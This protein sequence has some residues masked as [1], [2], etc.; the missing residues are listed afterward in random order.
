M[1]PRLH[2][3]SPRYDVGA[4][5][6]SSPPRAACVLFVLAQL[7]VGAA[8]DPVRFMLVSSP[9]DS[10]V[11]VAPLP[12]AEQFAEGL[13]L[14][15]AEVLID[16]VASKC[17]SNCDAES[18]LGLQSPE[19]LAVRHGPHNATLYVADY[20]AANI[21]SYKVEKR[22]AVLSI[23]TRDALKVGPQQ[24]VV[25]GVQGVRGL[26]VD[27]FGTLYFSTDTGT[28]GMVD[29]AAP[30]NGTG[31]YTPKILYQAPSQPTVSTPASVAASS[32]FVYWAN[33]AAGQSSGSV[34]KAS[35]HSSQDIAYSGNNATNMSNLVPAALATNSDK[36]YGVCLTS[37]SI[38]YTAEAQSVYG[39][40][41][42]GGGGAEVTA[43][44]QQPRGCV[45]DGEGFLYVADLQDQAV[46]AMSVGPTAVRPVDQLHRV[47]D[48]P[49][50]SQV[51][52]F[53]SCLRYVEGQEDNGFL[54]LGW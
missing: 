17:S 54:G 22:D 42:S 21:Y 4:A 14:K 11:Y 34:V 23:F 18:D 41:A 5:V 39:V 28:I 32:F 9:T 25:Q 15:R 10:N 3:A 7:M 46:Y 20:G 49:N 44:L 36:T 40:N 26:A 38:F 6:R 19:G 35:G 52:I 29:T 27:G 16:G 24:R 53:T 2:Q 51:A 30:K 50:P 8:V 37:T 31:V 33:E 45:H 13:Q 48:V 43:A 47:F 1:E 12:D